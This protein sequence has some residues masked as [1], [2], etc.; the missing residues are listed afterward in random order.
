MVPRPFLV[1]LVLALPV[2]VVAFAVVMAGYALSVA[3]GD[4]AG[5]RI[6][7]GFGT[8]CLMIGLIDAILLVGVLGLNALNGPGHRNEDSETDE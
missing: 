6:L 4:H 3:T 7:F 8:A 5:G 1:T 2:I